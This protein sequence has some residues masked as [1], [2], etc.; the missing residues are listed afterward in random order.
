MHTTSSGDRYHCLNTEYPAN[1]ERPGSGDIVPL[2]GP[3]NIVG[4]AYPM[5][6]KPPIG[7]PFSSAGSLSTH[8]RSNGERDA[9]YAQIAG[10]DRSAIPQN[11][12]YSDRE[13]LVARYSCRRKSSVKAMWSLRSYTRTE[14]RPNRYASFAKRSNISDICAL[15]R[16]PIE[17]FAYFLQRHVFPV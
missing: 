1:M 13:D 10:A 9:R 16:E 4:N 11:V 6:V 7:Q 12:R 3:T 2:R 14:Q 8:I 5:T 17:I 15:F